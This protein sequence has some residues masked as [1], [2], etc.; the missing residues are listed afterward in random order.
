MS[1]RT[2][3]TL[4]T[5][6]TV[7][8]ALFAFAGTAAAH[9]VTLTAELTGETEVDAEGNT[10]AGDPDGTGTSTITLNDEEGEVCWE[11]D[12]ENIML[13]AAASHIHVG[14]A[15]TAGDVV[16]PLTAPDATGHAEGC[17]SKVSSDLIAEIL[18]DP[19]GYYVNVHTEDYPGGA[20][21]G[22]LAAAEPPDTATTDPVP[23]STTPTAALLLLALA[24]VVGVR[25]A[26][27]RQTTRDG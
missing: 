4:S 12:V 20:V 9:E 7:V 13:P 21:R 23:Q 16:I 26:N 15:G 3:L 27:A 2:H 5:A 17:D 1:A 22:Q 11:T 24:A 25:V 14:E 6:L 18:A 8:A 19:A 10:G